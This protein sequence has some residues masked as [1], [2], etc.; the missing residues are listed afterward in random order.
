LF[1]NGPGLLDVKVIISTIRFDGDG[2][3]SAIAFRDGRAYFNNNFIHFSTTY[4]EEQQAGRI[5]AAFWHSKSLLACWLANAF[6]LRLE[7]LLTPTLFTGGKLCQHFIETADPMYRSH[8][9][10]IPQW[11]FSRQ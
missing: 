10:K 9:G 7:I 4:R 6:D 2:M 3:I 11:R 5:L 1:R 8:D